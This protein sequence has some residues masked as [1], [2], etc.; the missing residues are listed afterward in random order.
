MIDEAEP[1]THVGNVGWCRE[2]A[3]CIEVLFAWT[4]AFWGNLESC[5]LDGVS[6]EYKLVW[7]EGDVVVSAEVQ[8]VDCL[9][10]AFMH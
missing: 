10:E 3:D 8:P 5:K 6:S 7:I 2:F 1:R 9:G 4:H